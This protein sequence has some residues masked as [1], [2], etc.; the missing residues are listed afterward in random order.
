MP[1]LPTSVFDLA[2][3]MAESSPISAVKNFLHMSLDPI[4]V[5]TFEYIISFLKSLLDQRD[6]ND[7]TDGILANYLLEP[8]THSEELQNKTESEE[9]TADPGKRMRLLSLL[10]SS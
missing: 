9:N 3:Q 7:L 8:L 2:C 5:R 1:I 10:I 4:L 6:F